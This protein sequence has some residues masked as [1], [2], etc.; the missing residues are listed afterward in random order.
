MTSENT[1]KALAKIDE[2]LGSLGQKDY[3]TFRETL[4]RMSIIFANLAHWSERVAAISREELIKKMEVIPPAEQE[5]KFRLLLDAEVQLPN[6]GKAL[7]METARVFPRQLGGA[8]RVFKDRESM[9]N[10]VRLVL[11]FIEKGY[12]ESEAKRRAARKLHVS[13]QTMNRTWKRR[14]VLMTEPS[15]GEFFLQFLKQ[16]ST[17]S[18]G[19]GAEREKAGELRVSLPDKP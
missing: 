6:L 15:F 12:S 18:A 16:V 2:L 4:Q 1:R 10:A 5:Q 14:S 3:E 19:E 13:L 7:I 8:P 17:S 9:R 11:E